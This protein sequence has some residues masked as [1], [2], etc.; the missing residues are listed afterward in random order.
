MKKWL[1]ALLIATALLGTSRPTVAQSQSCNVLCNPI[2]I[3]QPGLFMTNVISPYENPTTGETAARVSEF[4]FRMATAIPTS[5]PRT[6][7]GVLAQWLPFATAGDTDYKTNSISFGYAA[8]V[9]VL[10]AASTNGILSFDVVPIG[11]F[12]PSALPEDNSAYS[13]KF[14]VEGIGYLNVGETLPR[15][16]PALFRRTSIHAITS[17]VATGLPDVADQWGIQVGLTVPIAPFPN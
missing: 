2:V 8:V 17:Y 4:Q 9:N 16:A 1:T 13:H 12:S 14:I 11:A 6:T 5:I 3:L 7:L 15:T 10:P